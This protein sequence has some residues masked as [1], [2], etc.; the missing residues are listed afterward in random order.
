MQNS[1]AIIGAGRVGR[2]LG[3]RLRELVWKIGAGVTPSEASGCKAV[4]FIGAGKPYAG[5]TRQ[6]LVSRVIL[7]AIPDD[8]IAVFAQELAR[9]AEEELR[10][11]MCLHTSG[12]LGATVLS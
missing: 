10:G 11:R 9:T 3:R 6:I 12:A 7:I 8:H 2:A 4:R 1:L 5:L